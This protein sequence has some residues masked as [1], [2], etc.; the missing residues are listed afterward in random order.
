MEMHRPTEGAEAYVADNGAAARDARPEDAAPRRS[1][2]VLPWAHRLSARREL[3]DQ[4]VSL[5]NL[6][7]RPV[8]SS[9]G[10]RVGRVNDLVVRWESRA[11]HPS[12]SGVLVK[13]GRGLALAPIGVVTLTQ[14]RAQFVA[15]P[16]TVAAPS[17]RAGDVA[18]ARD[19]LD[20]QL[21]D[22]EGVQVVRAADIYLV[23]VSDG[24][25]LAG[26]DVGTW[27]LLRR[28]LP[29]RRRCPPPDRVVDWA[30]LQAFV[31]RFPEDAPPRP[32]GPASAAGMSEGGVQLAYPAAR[33]HKLRAKDV[34]ELLSGLDRQPQAQLA[35]M[36]DPRAVGQV[37]AELGPAKLDALLSELDDTDRARLKALIS[38]R[39]Q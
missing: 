26:V 22:V 33:L 15:T 5:A 7:G 30:D 25:E 19:I 17:R 13:L 10:A 27:A 12:V 24:W 31:P 1:R 23:S 4:M 34:E 38:G 18:L 8:L 36:A 28:M 2:H 9:A 11:T 14:S 21:V 35:A 3:A 32:V 6:V 39:G 20:R 16:V 29:K 37:L